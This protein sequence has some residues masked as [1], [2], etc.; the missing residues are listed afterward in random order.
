[1]LLERDTSRGHG[2]EQALALTHE[3]GGE[4]TCPGTW[5]LGAYLLEGGGGSW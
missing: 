4:C 3:P 2:D 1:M 5:V